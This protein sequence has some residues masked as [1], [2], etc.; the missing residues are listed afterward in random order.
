M[1]VALDLSLNSTAMVV[2]HNEDHFFYNYTS[3]KTTRHKCMEFLNTKVFPSVKKN[4]NYSTDQNLKLQRILSITNAI[5]EDILHFVSNSQTNVSEVV[6]EGYSF[7][8]SSVSF[9]ELVCMGSL[10]RAFVIEELKCK[11]TIVSPGALKLATCKL[12]YNQKKDPI[13][14]LSGGRFK[15]HDMLRAC[16]TYALKNNQFNDFDKWLNDGEN[17]SSNYNM[18]SIPT[19]IEDICDAFFLLETTKQK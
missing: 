1:K 19:P 18:K 11:L 2:E 10:L 3:K 9:N 15:K 13:T 12:V 4:P 17:Y 16:K 7:G 8:S 14:K 5:K 6:I